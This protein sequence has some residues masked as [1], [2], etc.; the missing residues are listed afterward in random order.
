MQRFAEHMIERTTSRFAQ[1]SAEALAL[2]MG[3]R[4]RIALVERA[5]KVAAER[6]NRHV[7]FDL[8][9]QFRALAQALAPG[10]N[11][12]RRARL[13]KCDRNK[14][15]KTRIDVDIGAA[16][17]RMQQVSPGQRGVTQTYPR[18]PPRALGDDAIE[19]VESE[20]T[21]MLPEQF[22]GIPVRHQAEQRGVTIGDE[23]RGF[24]LATQYRNGGR[25]HGLDRDWAS[26]QQPHAAFSV[27]DELGL[28]WFPAS[29]TFDFP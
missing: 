12:A 5:I 19:Q 26:L 3:K 25:S 2:F 10:G 8:V 4:V 15:A 14:R 27:D 13:R 22:G 23:E 28:A 7:E 16:C 6:R 17:T 11:E 20:W 1:G 24:N 21:R 9:V 29:E 18:K